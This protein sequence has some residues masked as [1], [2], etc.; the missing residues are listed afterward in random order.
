L[1]ARA[2]QVVFYGLNVIN[3]LSY[4]AVALLE[5]AIV[6]IACAGPALR[7]SRLDP[8]IALRSE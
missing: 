1:A 5:C 2:L 7:A 8:L 4:A 6:L 3:P